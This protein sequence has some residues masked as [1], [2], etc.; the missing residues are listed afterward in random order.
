ML[1]FEYQVDSEMHRELCEWC[2]LE[3]FFKNNEQL[4][5]VIYI[6]KRFPS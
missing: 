5:G 1:Q 2:M 4:K 6:H 3:C